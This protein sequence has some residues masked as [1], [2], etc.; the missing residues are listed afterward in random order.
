M[1][2]TLYMLIW[3]PSSTLLHMLQA[4]SELS[5]CLCEA[6]ALA[7]VA[8]GAGGCGLRWAA[9][10][11]HTTLGGRTLC[12][13]AVKHVP[14][15]ASANCYTVACAT[16]HRPAAAA[17]YDV[18]AARG[19][20]R[21]LWDAGPP[22]HA[23]CRAPRVRGG[24]RHGQAHGGHTSGVGWLVGPHGCRRLQGGIQSRATSCRGDSGL[25][26]GVFKKNR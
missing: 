2:C 3:R 6:A 11:R 22:P 17:L 9:V 26:K 14:S 4:R 1:R 19:G 5:T 12:H 23:A 25:R 20:R 24:R 21:H 8:A 16:Q 7:G 13:R 10:V 15:M 18:A